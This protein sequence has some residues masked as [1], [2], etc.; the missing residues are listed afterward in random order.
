MCD[1][2]AIAALLIAAEVA[3][4]FAIGFSIAGAALSGN[5]F[6]GGASVAL[7]VA[8]LA[9]IAVAMAFLTL[10][11]QLLN[12]CRSGTCGTFAATAWNEA[13][14]ALAALAVLAAMC[15]ILT[16]ESSSQ[17]SASQS[18][19]EWSHQ[20]SLQASCSPSSPIGSLDSIRASPQ[21]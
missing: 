2:A 19:S 20:L 18:R 3:F 13:A 7:L 12:S 5:F 1:V 6:T 9:S 11:M 8:A 16:P 10:V 21:S 14:G 4:G 15:G 17:G